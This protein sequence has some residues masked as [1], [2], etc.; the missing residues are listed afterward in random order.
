M[1]WHQDLLS[2]LAVRTI[3]MRS[4]LAAR[5]T[6]QSSTEV[7]GDIINLKFQDSLQ[8]PKTCISEGDAFRVLSL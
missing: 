4:T 7:Q 8:L 3:E 2:T 6:Q 5:K 1:M